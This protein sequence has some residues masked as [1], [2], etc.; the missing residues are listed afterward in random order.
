MSKHQIRKIM[1][2]LILS[3]ILLTLSAVLSSQS[4]GYN[5]NR[6]AISADG[7]NQPDDHPEAQWPRADPD[8]WGGTPASLAMLAKQGLQ[9]QLVHYS[10]NNFIEAP[11]HTTER[12]YMAEAVN[13]AIQRWDFDESLFFD[14]PEND[15]LAITHLADQIKITT[16]S[17]PLFFIHMGPSEFFYRAVKQVIDSGNTDALSHVQVISH[18]GYNDD[19]LRRYAHHTMSEAI[20]LSGN[21]IKYKK[22]ADQNACDNPNQLWCSG[23]DF[24]PFIWME[25][26]N[27]P[28]I[29]WL[30]SRL[31]FHPGGKGADIS[32]AGM[33]FYLTMGDEFGNLAKF[34]EFIGIGIPIGPVTAV[35]GI[36]L[37][38]D[39]AKVYAG[40]VLELEAT[41]LPSDAWNKK[42]HWSSSNPE[43]AIV[44]STGQVQGLSEGEAYIIVLS[45]EGYYS[46][47]THVKVAVL[48][49]CLDLSYVGIQ[50]FEMKQI[51]TFAISYKDPGRNAVAVDASIYK[52]RFGATQK[53][54]DGVIGFYNI[55]LSSLTEIDGES[56][57][58]LRINNSLIG[59]FQNPVSSIDYTEYIHTFENILV[60]TGDLIQ[61]ESN[62]HSNNTIPEGE[63]FAFS[64]GRWRSIEFECT[65]ECRMEET[66]GLLVFEAERFPLKGQWKL[67]YDSDKASGGEYIYFSGPNSYTSVN[68]ADVISYTFKINNPGNYTV[69]WSMRQPEGERGTDKGNDVWIYLSDDRGYAESLKL[70]DYEK[71]Y[72]RSDDN[73]TLNG[74]AEVHNLGHRWLTAKFPSAG[75]YTLNIG[76]R[77]HGLQIDRLVFFKGMTIDEAEQKMKDLAE[78]SNCGSI[79][80]V[81]PPQ[82]YASPKS[83]VMPYLDTS[84]SID[85]IEEESWFFFALT[86][87]TLNPREENYH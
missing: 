59:E 65:G 21:R 29:Q 49:E 15:S 62:T 66:D 50:D 60:E 40:R 69:K 83:L 35:E 61:I 5:L 30:W 77:S 11:P 10:Y 71:F 51:D 58:R 63:G 70:E 72:G 44:S 55:S 4:L 19:H 67:G 25:E 39:S 36:L 53:I 20:A 43:I 38:P 9:D 52:N 47:T 1:R 24:T 56:S 64:R 17:D 82:V 80:P 85:G 2:L 28:N 41:I 37:V 86:L 8:D 75:E 33:V 45:D 78:T 42:T 23:T 7:N 22:I 27:D 74:V 68:S 13:G 79:V 84:L 87:E 6:I 76:G 3:I 34:E 57:Y 73:F 32:D 16:A 48:P 46:D 31:Q 54:F 18:S 26:H 12:N 81:E 14:V